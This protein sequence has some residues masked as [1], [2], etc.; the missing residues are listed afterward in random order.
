MKVLIYFADPM[1]SWCWGFTPQIRKLSDHFSRRLPIGMM[2][3]GLRVGTSEPV[4]TEMTE[5]LRSAWSAVAE[6][7]GQP[8]DFS[9]LEREGFVYDTEPACR[10]VVTVREM[11]A[12][13][14]LTYFS[15]LQQAFYAEG[16]D[17]TSTDTLADLAVEAGVVREDFITSFGG[18][19]SALKTAEDFQMSQ[20]AGVRGFPTLIASDEQG[21]RLVSSGYREVEDLIPA[22]EAWLGETT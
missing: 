9:F 17:P 21:L 6:R 13:S 8:F 4:D 20:N 2:M 14:T 12:E 19:S 15:S 11:A 7:T 1:C 16:R 22:L 10:A 5:Y 18:V 3:G